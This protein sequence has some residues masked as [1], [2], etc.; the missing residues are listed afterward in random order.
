MKFGGKV[1]WLCLILV[2]NTEYDFIPFGLFNKFFYRRT[3]VPY[4]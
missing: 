1:D 3:G 4:I 2:E